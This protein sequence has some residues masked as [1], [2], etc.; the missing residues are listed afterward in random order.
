MQAELQ[1]EMA[2]VDAEYEGRS[3]YAKGLAKMAYSG[4][5]AAIE[6]RYG[7]GLDGHSHGE[8]FLALFQADSCPTAFI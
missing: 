7:E 4:Q 3:D 8:A 1:T 6:E 5:L 2:N